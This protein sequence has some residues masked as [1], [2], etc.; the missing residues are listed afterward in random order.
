MRDTE[1]Q[2]RQ[3]KTASDTNPQDPRV[4]QAIDEAILHWLEVD[5]EELATPVSEEIKEEIQD[6]IMA[7]NTDA[8][9]VADGVSESQLLAAKQDLLNLNNGRPRPLGVITRAQPD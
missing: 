7:G 9:I 6:S 5:D 1:S 3:L 8:E 4:K 2:I